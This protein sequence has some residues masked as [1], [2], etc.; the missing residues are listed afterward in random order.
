LEVQKPHKWR[1]DEHGELH[2][3]VGCIGGGV[4]EGEGAVEALQRE[5][6]EEMGCGIELCEAPVTYA[7]GPDCQVGEVEWQAAGARPAL[8]WEACLPGLIPGRSV[9]VFRGRAAGEPM[10][11]DLPALLMVRPEML[12]MIGGAGLRL[13]EALKLGAVLKARMTIPDMAW[14]E[15]VGTPAVINLLRDN[16]DPWLKLAILKKEAD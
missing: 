4:D 3:G 2:I 7:V 5:A 11:G 1:V 6:V 16:T 12:F 9:A 15:L 14:L 8:V 10:P 13:S